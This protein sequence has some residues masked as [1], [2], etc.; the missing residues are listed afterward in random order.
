MP[1]PST[2]KSGCGE[3]HDPGDR[4]EQPDADAEREDEAEP[5]R[6]LALA[7]GQAATRIAMKTTLSMPSTISI[8]ESVA[9]A[10]R[11]S[12]VRSSLDYL[13]RGRTCRANSSIAARSS[14]SSICSSTRWTPA[15][16]HS[17]S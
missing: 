5:P 11:P 14:W 8:A 15:S 17:R 1:R 12:V 10:T 4:E 9:S 2:V 16:S 3:A 13:T 6:E 7:L